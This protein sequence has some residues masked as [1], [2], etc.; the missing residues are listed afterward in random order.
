MKKH[1]TY[2]GQK[3]NIDDRYNDYIKNGIIKQTDENKKIRFIA[4]NRRD[5]IIQNY[6]KKGYTLPTSWMMYE[7]YDHF[8][9][10]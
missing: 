2:N 3:I 6:M 4:N 7:M 10:L 8:F 9:I 1:I 5:I